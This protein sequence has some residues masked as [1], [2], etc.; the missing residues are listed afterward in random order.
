M[1]TGRI[2]SKELEDKIIKYLLERGVEFT[3]QWV[4]YIFSARSRKEFQA[5]IKTLG[6]SDLL[7]FQKELNEFGKGANYLNRI[8]ADIRDEIIKQI[9]NALFVALMKGM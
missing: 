6:T 1:A 2:I 8:N 5:L 3:K 7:A 4:S 9:I